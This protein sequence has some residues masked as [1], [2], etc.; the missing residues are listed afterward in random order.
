MGTTLIL[1]VSGPGE[2]D[3][4]KFRMPSGQ[5]LDV[6][7]IETADGVTFKSLENTTSCQI[8][9]D[10]ITEKMLGG[11]QIIGKYSNGNQFSEKRQIFQIVKEGMLARG[12]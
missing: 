5:A 4:C 6:Y 12:L 11:W 7:D 1:E 10:S 3:V 2:L 8:V 9:F